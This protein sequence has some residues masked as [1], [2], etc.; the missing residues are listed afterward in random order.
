MTLSF[1]L[2]MVLGCSN[3]GI[4]NIKYKGPIIDAIKKG[5]EKKL[6]KVIDKNKDKLNT[7]NKKGLYPLHYAINNNEKLVELLIQMGADINQVDESGKAPL[8][9]AAERKNEYVVEQL[10]KKGANI[11]T[12]NGD[13]NT[14]IHLASYA[15][16][17]DTTLVLVEKGANLNL[18]N[19]EGNTPL[20]LALSRGLEVVA[21]LLIEKGADTTV[22]NISGETPLIIAVGY[23]P[24]LVKLLK[25][26]KLSD[27]L[28]D[29]MKNSNLGKVEDLIDEG[30]DLNKKYGLEDTL[31]HMTVKNNLMNTLRMLLKAGADINIFNK[32]GNTPFYLACKENNI[33]IVKE[34]I[35]LGAD[36]NKSNKSCYTP[37]FQVIENGNFEIFMELLRGGVNL[38]IEDND[39]NTILHIAASKSRIE[40]VLELIKRGAKLNENNN[41]FETPIFQAALNGHE[42][43]V[44]ELI[45]AGAKINVD[46]YMGNTPL[47]LAVYAGNKNIVE[48]LI[49]AGADLST[50]NRNGE[51]LI[52]IA[53]NKGHNEILE[54]L[55]KKP[56]ASKMAPNKGFSTKY[57]MSSMKANSLKNLKNNSN[58]YSINKKNDDIN[59]NL[60]VAQY[61]KSKVDKS[62]KVINTASLNIKQKTSVMEGDKN[63]EDAKAKELM[64]AFIK[65]NKE[66][67]L[68]KQKEEDLKDL[69]EE[70]DIVIAA[71]IEEKG[72]ELS[73]EK[74][75]IKK[76][77][78]SL[79]SLYK[80][81][82][83]KVEEF[84]EA[85]TGPEAMTSLAHLREQ[86]S[87]ERGEQAKKLDQAK[88][89]RAQKEKITEIQVV[90]HLREGALTQKIKSLSDEAAQSPKVERKKEIRN[91]SKQLM[92]E[93]DD[94]DD[95][96]EKTI[97]K[98]NNPLLAYLDD[99]HSWKQH[100][101]YKY[102]EMNMGN[103]LM[104]Y[105]AIGMGT[106]DRQKGFF[107]KNI[108]TA[109]G[110]ATSF[111]PFG[112]SMVKK[113][114]E[115]AIEIYYD[116]NMKKQITKVVSLYD[117]GGIKGAA[118][119]S[120]K[121]AGLFVYKLKNP[122]RELNVDSLEV[123]AGL[124]IGQMV[125]YTI[126]HWDRYESKSVEKE[127]FLLEA[128]EHKPKWHSLPGLQ[129]DLKT[130]DGDCCDAWKLLAGEEYRVERTNIHKNAKE[131]CKAIK[132][133]SEVFIDYMMEKAE[134][135]IE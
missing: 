32:E 100:I 122:I 7:E 24:S 5:D 26:V 84:N 11:D 98:L 73:K 2:L 52:D 6:E 39:G 90:R 69:I 132:K 124:A 54:I 127:E 106:V 123:L 17:K 37:L 20:L 53:T 92:E 66:N 19:K 87:K 29:A 8:H 22:A 117:Y 36:L 33:E 71:N 125:D 10:I 75:K 65:Q 74:D 63:K 41:G 4:T 112:G 99:Y 67:I 80:K 129:Q 115:K 34:L 94:L 27:N 118:D 70:I 46:D 45:K 40:M 133:Y 104:K 55:I 61:K 14:P 103:E 102:L 101:F 86:V 13:G 113:G 64:S 114:L 56:E 72:E 134:D 88:L 77:K 9:H 95:E 15:G 121:M 3:Y 60:K 76:C 120:S 21:K 18:Q 91:R 85:I 59:F 93:L 82:K 131:L 97:K 111:L 79:Q 31:L 44:T 38:N 89:A 105:E 109:G 68:S 16:D 110:I 126:N 1:L 135:S 50:V 12:K 81:A 49:N 48:K 96:Y 62:T 119:L 58:I 28:F 130:E 116:R 35:K 83:S 108:T 128:T 78:T 23:C 51:S 107:E 43:V 47:S 30:A 57:S 42:E 25:S